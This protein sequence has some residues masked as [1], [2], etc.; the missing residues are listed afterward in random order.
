MANLCDYRDKQNMC[1]GSIQEAIPCVYC[2]D[3]DI[4]TPSNPRYMMQTESY[5]CPYHQGK[6]MQSYHK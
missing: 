2:A 3:G 5:Y 1:N 4:K 6:H